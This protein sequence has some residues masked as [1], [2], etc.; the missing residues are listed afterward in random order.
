MSGK[1]PVEATA[2]AEGSRSLWWLWGLLFLLL[3]VPFVLPIPLLLE[4]NYVLRS[5]G[6]QLHVVLFLAIVLLL[7]RRGPLAGRLVAV[8]VVTLGLGGLVELVQ[9]LCGRHARLRDFGLDALGVALAGCWI[10]WRAVRSRRTIWLGICCLL[11]VVF[12]LHH[13]PFWLVARQQAAA[14]FPLLFDGETRFESRLWGESYD[15]RVERSGDGSGGHVLRLAGEPP[16]VYPGID[17]RGFP[18]DWS[19]YRRLS[20][21]ARAVTDGADSVRYIVRLDDY[22]GHLEGVW[23]A[24]RYLA[25]SEWRQFSLDLH[26]QRTNTGTRG[27]YLDDVYALLFCL[28]APL[29]PTAIELDDI[30]L[31]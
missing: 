7:H 18:A 22:R 11:L 4:R 10:Q 30:R 2:A 31:E 25:G 20:W 15:S 12:Q 26:S 28:P 24:R 13:L 16:S 1:P 21:R 8:A 19:P 23:L 9:E 29:A 3:L 6:N 14:R 17:C 27:L 5:L